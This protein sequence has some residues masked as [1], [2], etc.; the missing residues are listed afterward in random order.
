M[1]PPKR[2][3]SR[4]SAWNILSNTSSSSRLWALVWA[5]GGGIAPPTTDLHGKAPSLD[6]GFISLSHT[7][8]DS[9]GLAQNHATHFADLCL[10]RQCAAAVRARDDAVNGAFVWRS[11]GSYLCHRAPVCRRIT[12]AGRWHRP[13]PNWCMGADGLRDN[14]P[15][16]PSS[17][18]ARRGSEA[19]AP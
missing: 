5:V 13:A 19:Q 1:I 11:V 18:H 7:V 4:G 8:T 16:R 17:A 3:L 9:D 6:G 15:A 2:R 14:G 12:S 10:P